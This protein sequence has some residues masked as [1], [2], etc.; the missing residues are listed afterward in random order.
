LFRAASQAVTS[1]I[2]ICCV[3]MQN[4]LRSNDGRH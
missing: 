2:S 1:S 4:Q 3:E